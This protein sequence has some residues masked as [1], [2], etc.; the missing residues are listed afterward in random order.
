[1]RFAF[2]LSKLKGMDLGSTT[3]ILGMLVGISILIESI[4][5]NNNHF[6]Y[7]VVAFLPSLLYIFLRKK[8]RDRDSPNVLFSKNFILTCVVIFF[9]AI[10]LII[11][12]SHTNTHYRPTMYFFLC[13]LATVPIMLH[14]FGYDTKKNYYLWL[15]L[16]E[17]IFLSYG[18]D[19]WWHTQWI[20][21]TIG[22]GHITPGQYLTNPY[23]N[24]PMFHLLSGITSTISLLSIHDATFISIGIAGNC[25]IP[26]LFIFLIAKKLFDDKI[27][28]LSALLYSLFGYSIERGISIIPMTLGVSLFIIALYLVFILNSKRTHKAIYLMLFLLFLSALALT[29]ALAT[30]IAFIS[31]VTIYIGNVVYKKMFNIKG[32]VNL[33]NI[34]MLISLII[35][36]T[37]IIFTWSMRGPNHQS[38]LDKVVIPSITHIFSS[39]SIT[40][41]NL[42]EC[43]LPYGISL[44]VRSSFWLL[45]FFTIF[46]SLFSLSKKE[47]S[48]EK[49][50]MILI[51]LVLYSSVTVSRILS[52]HILPWRWYIFMMVPL[53]I[54]G[55][56]GLFKLCS[57]MKG[58]HAV[59]LVGIGL[60]II[61]IIFLAFILVILPAEL[62]GQNRR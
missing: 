22:T 29:H 5:C 59:K 41:N 49:F 14:I 3:A 24:L 25:V 27:A 44:L 16:L 45:M 36:G 39:A 13:S 38:L 2:N 20:K 55:V 6:H 10:S 9:L 7:F 52:V 43:P 12:I 32:N 46:A 61:S 58:H 28:L 62:P 60:V 40:S 26:T 21:E 34:I 51:F 31:I 1:M 54:L 57:F 4:V 11:W 35:F 48:E 50:I 33:R 30:L 23:Y 37:M 17:I 56:A 8:V 19:P 18:Q 42:L 47:R 53:S 15:I